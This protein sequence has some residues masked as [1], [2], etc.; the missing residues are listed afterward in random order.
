MRL[1]VFKKSVKTQIEK[2]PFTILEIRTHFGGLKKDHQYKKGYTNM[3][4]KDGNSLQVDFC[5][6]I[7]KEELVITDISVEGIEI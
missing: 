4:T 7:K 6:V 3:I 5:Y 2:S 1:K